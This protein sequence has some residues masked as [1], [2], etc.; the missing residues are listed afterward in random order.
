MK[1][2]MTDKQ[3]KEVWDLYHKS[4]NPKD[5]ADEFGYDETEVIEYCAEIL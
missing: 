5:I 1:K 2:R 3:K 4:W